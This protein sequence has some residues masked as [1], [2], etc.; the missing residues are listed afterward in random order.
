MAFFF[1]VEEGVGER[2]SRRWNCLIFNV[3]EICSFLLKYFLPW[4]GGGIA[5]PRPGHW[6]AD[7]N[8]SSIE[9]YISSS[10]C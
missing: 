9:I 6:F 1:G 10:T 4:G 3:D 2:R 7:R 5:R 8:V